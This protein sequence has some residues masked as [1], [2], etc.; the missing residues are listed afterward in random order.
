MTLKNLFYSI[1]IFCFGFSNTIEFNYHNKSF[2]LID[3]HFIVNNAN[4]SKKIDDYTFD[5]FRLEFI[6][7]KE[8]LDFNITNI[9]WIDTDIEIHDMNLD[10]IIEESKPFDYKSCPM[11]FFDIF[12]YKI[13]DQN[14]LSF[15]KTIS[16][17]FNINN[18][19]LENYCQPEE[20]VKN[21][22]F[23]KTKQYSRSERD[24][25]YLVLTEIEFLDAANKLREIHEDLD[26]DIIDLNQII[27][28]N[29]SNQ[30]EYQIR[31]YLLNRINNEFSLKYLLILGDETIVP[32]IYNGSIP[33]DDYYTSPGILSGNPQLSTGRIPVD[34]ILDAEN[35]LIKLENYLE[36]IINDS[37]ISDAWRMTVSLLSDDENNP[38]PNKYPELSHTEN[39]NLIYNQISRNFIVNPLYGIDYIPQQDSDGLLH[40]QFTNEIISNINNG[41]SLINYIGH[42]NHNTLADEK[43]IQMERDLNLINVQQNKLPI[44]VVGTCSFGEYDGKDSMSEELIKSENAAISVISTTR[45]IGEISNINY[46]TKFFE[47]VNDFIEDHANDDR[48]GDLIRKSKNNSSSEYLFHLFGDPAMPLPFPKLRVDPI[49]SFPNDLI[50]G[51]QSFVDFNDLNGFIEIYDSEKSI[52]KY[53]SNGDSINYTVPGNTVY[54]GSFDQNL[55]FTTSLDASICN[56]CAKAYTYII[57]DNYNLS[58]NISDINIISNDNISQDIIGPQIN[59]YS[60]DF[61]EILDNDNL[62]AG[63]KITVKVND[64]SGINLMGG[65][66]HN[67]RYWFNDEDNYQIIEPESFQYISNCNEVSEGKFSIDIPNLNFGDNILFVEIWDNLNNKT[68]SNLSFNLKSFSLELYDVYNFP[69]PFDA[70]TFFTFRTS[71]YPISVDLKIFDLKGNKVKSFS[72]DCISSFC[73]IYWN[74]RNNQ[75]KFIENGTYIYSIEIKNNNNS[76]KNLYK[77]TKIK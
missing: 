14:K 42:G 11:I 65:L 72:E 1:L 47:K 12:P 54:R 59:F 62:Y 7:E 51:M 43:I 70:D 57:D 2:S 15:I 34:N 68:L 56:G 73:S 4:A 37:N 66:G 13:T 22:Q 32:P 55:C 3:N 9:E 17:S 36:S 6:I 35:Y 58:K 75:N 49:D 53:Y 19:V 28:L 63:S 18:I 33:S 40:T 61:I 44:W 38:N 60:D 45:G 23:I 52:S 64:P 71:I 39:S 74:G 26:I 48:L 25:D 21:K 27:D 10:T 50:I 24:Y 77:L 67:I 76:Y 8:R 41:L 69:N 29:N 20:N 31:D 30:A 46:L 16:I 5:Y